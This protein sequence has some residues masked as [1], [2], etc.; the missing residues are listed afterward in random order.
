MSAEKH[1]NPAIHQRLR[2]I[3]ASGDYVNLSDYLDSLSNAMFRTAG[4]ILGEQIMPSV[5]SGKFWELFI[6]LVRYNSKAFLTTCLKSLVGRMRSNTI[7]LSEEGYREL[8]FILSANSIDVQ[9]T[10][11]MLLP[12]MSSVEQVK[13][14]FLSLGES[15]PSAWIPYLL[16]CRTIY[17][18][19][20]LFSSL[21]YIE[22]DHD[23]LCRI[24]YFLMKNG[25]E[26][27]F[28]LASLMKTYFALNELKG[29][30]SLSLKP[31]ELARIEASFESFRNAMSY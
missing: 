10:I 23:Q 13:S 17:A 11:Q 18:Y 12:E 19:Y 2:V 29:T 20:V 28:N 5:S 8:C 22:H 9:K 15:D 3:I 21:R 16:K 27:S 14:L 25:D 6:L 30:F 4:Y 7:S 31:F 24:A 26:M 1:F